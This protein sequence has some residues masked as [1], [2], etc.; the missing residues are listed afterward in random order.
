MRE[1]EQRVAWTATIEA[2]LRFV[3]TGSEAAVGRVPALLHSS[4]S[5]SVDLRS[6]S[7]CAGVPWASAETT[8]SGRETG[9]PVTS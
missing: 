8:A 3:H 9:S 2:L 5:R 4:W 6:C 7:S 1:W